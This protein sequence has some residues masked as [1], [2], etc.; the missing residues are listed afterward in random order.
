MPTEHQFDVPGPVN[1]EVRVA[2]GDITITTADVD[3]ARIS[4]SGSQRLM[5]TT[6][7]S[8]HGSTL[9]IK[10]AKEKGLLA[11]LGGGDPRSLLTDGHLGIDVV[12]PDG[13]S[14]D[15]A[16]A[17]SDADLRGEFINVS[18]KSASGDLTV[19]GEVFGDVSVKNVSGDVDIE[20]VGGDI[21]CQSVSG[22]LTVAV[23]DGSVTATSV[24]GDISL[25][26][27]CSGSVRV[28]SVS[29]DVELGVARG[30][31]VD[32]EAT[33]ASGNMHSDVPLTDAPVPGEGSVVVIRAKTVSGEVHITR[34]PERERL[35]N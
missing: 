6:T 19:R 5:D 13:S 9:S 24:S 27:L 21:R 32:V 23:P 17:S 33:S 15:L 28:Q 20:H 7:V 26:S 18:A 16:S 3:E 29:G 1:V 25:R 31:G 10:Q 11:L 30:T 34:A 12:V 14:A 2:S 22:D 4:L 35:R 8:M